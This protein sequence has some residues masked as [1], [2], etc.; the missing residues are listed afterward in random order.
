MRLILDRIYAVAFRSLRDGAQA[1]DATQR[2][3][4]AAWR[5]LPT[6]EGAGIS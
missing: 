4:V 6:P 3:M 2:A 1:E 5:R